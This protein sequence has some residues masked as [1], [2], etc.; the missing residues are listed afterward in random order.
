MR[1]ATLI[2]TGW[3]CL[4]A[5]A[6]QQDIRPLER[7]VDDLGAA[8]AALDKKMD[9]LQAS[10]AR[11]R[12]PKPPS[13]PEPDSKD[14][15][16]V[17]VDGAASVGPAD[18]LVTIIKGYE[19]AC[20]YCEKVNP[21]LEQLRSDYG[22]DLRI[23]Y[24]HYVVHPKDATDPALAVCAATRQ[25]KFREMDALLWSRAYATRRFDRAHL[26][27]LAGEAG[28]DLAKY[29]ADLDGDC[30]AIIAKDQADLRAAGLGA[31]PTFYINGRYISGA[32]PIAQFKAMIDEELATARQRV[33]VG[34]PR[35]DYYRTWVLEKGL[36][37]FVPSA[38]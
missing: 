18:A 9:A 34:T 27:T 28:L 20:P 37:K 4:A 11:P 25:G 31:T 6:C 12:P 7:K 5:A 26:E 23:V 30:P 36:K 1:T 32:K 24:K 15:Y 33:A 17:P 14:V 2:V 35:A 21:T 22:D 16:A 10:I 19:Y 29:R 13:K 8:V 38:P 3:V